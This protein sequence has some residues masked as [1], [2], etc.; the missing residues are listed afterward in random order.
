MKNFDPPFTPYV[1]FSLK[2]IIQLDVNAN[3]LQ[4]FQEKTD[5]NLRS[6]GERQFFGR[7]KMPT[8]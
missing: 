4:N 3:K 5:E 6:I 2:W 8:L 7:I 1:E